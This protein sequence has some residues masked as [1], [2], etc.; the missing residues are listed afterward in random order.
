MMSVAK[1]GPLRRNTPWRIFWRID[2]VARGSAIQPAGGETEPRTPIANANALR[3]KTTVQDT[4]EI[5]ARAAAR[6]ALTLRGPARLGSNIGAL[7]CSVIGDPPHPGYCPLVSRPRAPPNFSRPEITKR[8]TE[9]GI[10]AVL[11]LYCA[12][13]G[14]QQ[15]FSS[16]DE[17][18][19]RPFRD[20]ARVIGHA[21]KRP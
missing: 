21:T 5:P 7:L 13:A 12:T 11:W 4:R 14:K 17:R 2:I 20:D 3:G 10:P 8:V 19:V 6:L 16:A 15:P 9:P 18:V 1:F